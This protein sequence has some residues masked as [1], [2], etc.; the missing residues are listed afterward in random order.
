[1]RF[2]ITGINELDSIIR[3]APERAGRLGDEALEEEAETI[4]R[5]S[6]EEVPVDTGALQESGR[7]GTDLAGIN[8]GQVVRSVTYGGGA[9]DYAWVVHEDLEVRHAS[10]K[11]AK[12]LED[13]ATRAADRLNGT[14][15]KGWRRVFRRT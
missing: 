13:P 15:A 6:Q 7:I 9:V 2:V 11:K 5:E 10:G 8:L 3:A 4:L 1:M 14:M 12:Y